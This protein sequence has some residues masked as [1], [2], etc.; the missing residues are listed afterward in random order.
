MNNQY[1]CNCYHGLAS[2]GDSL[3]GMIW[4]NKE[5]SELVYKY[6]G[7]CEVMSILLKKLLNNQL[8]TKLTLAKI[9]AKN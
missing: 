8:M 3:E 7:K 1:Y 4:I 5:N 6:Q 2:A 9:N